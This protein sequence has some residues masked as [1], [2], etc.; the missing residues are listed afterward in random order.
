[1][2]CHLLDIAL[3]KTFI[4]KVEN[5]IVSPGFGEINMKKDTVKPFFFNDMEVA[6]AVERHLIFSNIK[7]PH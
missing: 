5:C 3:A 6:T 2:Y 7:N 1:M 4:V